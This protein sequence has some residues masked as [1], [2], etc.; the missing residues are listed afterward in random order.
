[1]LRR[2]EVVSN[3]PAAVKVIEFRDLDFKSA[4]KEV[5]SY[6]RRKGEAYASDASFDLQIE[7]DLVCR[8]MDVLEEE[9]KLE[10]VK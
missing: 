4:K 6:F 3:D 5:S 7:Y 2:I 8:I 1:M 9:G 10:P